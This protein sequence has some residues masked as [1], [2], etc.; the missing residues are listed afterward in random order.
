M[1][2]FLIKV[3]LFCLPFMIFYASAEYYCLK[4]TNFSIKKMYLEANL[5]SIEVL[6]LGSSHSQN[7]INPEYMNKSTCNLAFGGQPL[8]IDYYLLEKYIPQMPHLKTVCVEVSPHRFFDDLE[9]AKWNSHIYANLYGIKYNVETFSLKN[10]SLVFSDPKFFTSTFIDYID[11]NS[12]K[13][14]L[15]KYGFVTNDS[16]DRFKELN[17]DSV[18]INSY[19]I[20]KH[21]YNN[22]TNF[23]NNKIF[24]AKII[25]LCKNKGVEL[26]LLSPPLY[27]TYLK[28]IP[29]NPEKKVNLLLTENILKYGIRFLD[30]SKDTAFH[31]TDFK[32]DNH[33][34]SNGAKKLTLKIN[35]ELNA[36]AAKPAH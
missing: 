13:Y 18:K 25:T 17:N 2:K 30:H 4:I 12:F 10:Y 16:N 31:L 22:Q 33:L 23:E 14:Q 6:I 7:A 11:P 26:V 32:N 28:H 29:V 19:Y 1:K 9:I 34:N 35:S 21:K 20:M 24:F 8:S 27:Q 36:T 15:N 5:K 3:F